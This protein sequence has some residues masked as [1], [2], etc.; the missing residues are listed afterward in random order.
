MTVNRFSG[1][2]LWDAQGRTWTKQRGWLLWTE[3]DYGLRSG[4]RLAIHQY[5]GP[6]RWLTASQAQDWWSDHRR[7]TQNGQAAAGT[8][9]DEGFHYAIAWWHHEGVTLLVAEGFC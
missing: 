4:H 9:D 2:R 7:T 3:T 5:R 6:V 1:D 8:P